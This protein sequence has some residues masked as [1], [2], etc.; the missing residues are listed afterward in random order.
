MKREDYYSHLNN[1]YTFIEY[2]ASIWNESNIKPPKK[3]NL[4]CLNFKNNKQDN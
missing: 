4:D 3:E 1:K 2:L